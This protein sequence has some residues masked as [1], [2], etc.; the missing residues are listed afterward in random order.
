MK[1]LILGLNYDPEYIGIGKYTGEMARWLAKRGHAVNVVTAP[2]YYPKWLIGKGYSPFRYK[3]ET[4]DGVNV[5]RCPLYVPQMPMGLARILHHF[6]FCLSSFAAVVYMVPWRPDVIVNV[7]PSF[8]STGA[9]LVS[10]SVCRCKSWLHIQDFELDAA[11]GLGILNA[12]KIRK[13]GETIEPMVYKKFDIVSTISSTML[14]KLQKRKGTTMS[15]YLFPN[16]VDTD[17]IFPLTDQQPLRRSFGC[18][19][20]AVIAL[21]SGNIANKQGLEMVIETARALGA[22]KYIQFIICGE[23]PEK[24]K[25]IS[26]AAGLTNIRFLPLQPPHKLNLLLNLA[27]I[28]LLPQRP[29]AADLVMPSKLT[30][31]MSSGKPVVAISPPGTEIE[32]IVSGRGIVIRPGKIDDFTSAVRWLALHPDERKKLGIAA[33]AYAIE[34]FNKEIILNRF[35]TRLSEITC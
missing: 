12:A 11:F 33:R 32:K 13:F 28:H 15:A 34:T 31:I 1:I 25:L 30:G 27:D 35:E 8:L 22:E 5:I 3:R 16:W 17:E 6:S 14:K 19:N 2:P 20:A 29:E 18:D 24:S 7:I 10:A 4:I 21:Y 23:G 26:L 9:A